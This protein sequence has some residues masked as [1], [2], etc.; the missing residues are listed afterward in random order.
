M[1]SDWYAGR[2]GAKQRQE[3]RLWRD[4][5]AYLERFLKKKNYA[6][7]A[8]RLGIPAKLEAARETLKRV[9]A[10]AYLESLKGTIG[11]QP[12]EK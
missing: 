6:D 4:H 1:A 12:L 2:L 5:I 10:D 11:L 9:N 7:E 3:G 8:A